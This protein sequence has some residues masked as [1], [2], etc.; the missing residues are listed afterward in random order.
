[1]LRNG[2]QRLADD[3][4]ALNKVLAELQHLLSRGDVTEAYLELDLFWTRLAVHIRAEHLHL[5]PTILF[6]AA[7]TPTGESDMPGLSLSRAEL[8]IEQL[9]G[10]HDFFMTELARCILSMRQL[11]GQEHE[12]VV[13]ELRRIQET[14]KEIDRRLALHNDVEETE[15][16]TWVDSLSD[17]KQEELM[18]VIDA[19]LTNLPS[20]LQRDR[21]NV[22]ENSQRS[23]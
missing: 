14:I 16:Y 15:V 9:R 5:F 21:R 18:Q 13:P 8:L 11:F 19:E 12:H 22:G 3:H 17:E 4:S 7:R 6:E 2:A 10:D 23:S 20:R 1:M